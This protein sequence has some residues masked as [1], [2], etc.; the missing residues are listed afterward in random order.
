MYSS[1]SN[2]PDITAPDSICYYSEST[3]LGFSNAT[4]DLAVYFD[5][6]IGKS[7][8]YAVS[9]IKVEADSKI[10]NAAGVMT[11]FAGLLR[12]IGYAG[13]LHHPV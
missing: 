11:S 7:T 5:S 13:A 12:N 2:M 9:I 4:D 1:L 3:G 6:N 8:G 10:C